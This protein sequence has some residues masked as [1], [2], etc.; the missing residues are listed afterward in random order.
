LNYRRQ[1]VRTRKREGLTLSRYYIPAS[2]LEK[3]KRTFLPEFLR[4]GEKTRRIRDQGVTL[5][6]LAKML[7]VTP[8]RLRYWC[9]RGDIAA[10]SVRDESGHSHLVIPRDQAK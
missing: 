9:H 3:F 1:A 4:E 7:N 8:A 6:D 5:T 10:A 2:E